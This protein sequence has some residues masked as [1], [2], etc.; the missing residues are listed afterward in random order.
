MSPPDWTQV[1]SPVIKL[2]NELGV[3]YQVGGS[4][5][6]SAWGMPRSTQDADLV[7]DLGFQHIDPLVAGL[8][9]AYYI[10]A[11]MIREAIVRRSAFN[12]LHLDTMLKVDIF[13]PELTA[14]DE[15]TFHH[16]RTQSLGEPQAEQA[17]FTSPEDI[18]LHKLLWYRAGGGISERQWL[19]VLGVLKVQAEA[20]DATYLQEWG[21][22]LGVSE[23]LA[24]A[25]QE[26]GLL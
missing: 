25:W 20:L 24:R 3:R 15:A 9:D 23:L 21:T 4:L 13:I 18:V 17:L 11:S 6:A 22:R 1:L 8:H 14:F 19:D 7:A 12:I 2:F 5:A 10:E 16:A 26:A